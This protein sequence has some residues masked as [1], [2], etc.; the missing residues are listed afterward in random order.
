MDFKFKFDENFGV[1]AANA[2][3]DA[4]EKYTKLIEEAKGKEVEYTNREA[5]VNAM[6]TKLDENF[7]ESYS[8]IMY[9][10]FMSLNAAKNVGD[11]F[12]G[13]IMLEDINGIFAKNGIDGV[14]LEVVDEAVKTDG[15]D[16]LN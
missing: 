11:K 16:N 8:R 2:M 12:A 13:K 7:D 14:R 15:R 9:S 1:K 6:L 5:I 4:F 10:V 3:T